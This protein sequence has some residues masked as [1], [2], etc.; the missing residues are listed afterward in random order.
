MSKKNKLWLVFGI[1]IT[2]LLSSCNCANAQVELFEVIADSPIGGELVTSLTPLFDWHGSYTCDPDEYDLFIKEDVMYGGD[3]AYSD[4]IY[5]DVPYTL[6]GYSLLPGRA[7]YWYARAHNVYTSPED[8]SAYGPDSDPAYFFTGPVCSGET[9]IAPELRFPRKHGGY[10]ET[11]NWITHNHLQEFKWTYTGGCLPVSYDYQFALDAGFTEIVLSETTTEPYVQHIFEPFSNCSSLFWRVRAND[12]TSV[13]PWSDAWQFHWVREGTSCYQTHFLSDDF[14]WLHVRLA[15]DLCDQTGYIAAWT[16]TLN[17]GCKVDGMIIVGDNSKVIDLTNFVVDLGAGPCPS[18]GLDQK[19]ANSEAKFGVLTP[20]TYCF[21]ISRNQS[22]GWNNQTYLM[23]GIWTFPRTNAVVAER[24][25]ELGP[26][27][28]DEN[29][30]FNWDEVDRTFLT[31]PLDY[32]Y[33]C[34]Y[35]PEKIC[36]TNGFAQAGETIPIL[37]R[38]SRSEWM[39]TQLN[40]TPCYVHIPG[41]LIDEYLTKFGPEGSRVAD[42]EIFPQPPPC[43]KPTPEP[44]CSSYSSQASCPARCTWHSSP[45]AAGGTCS[46]N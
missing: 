24:T 20:G 36:P 13:G 9:L 4:V 10:P 26:G 14:A 33:G 15:E 19:T 45:L 17:P 30:Q 3:S 29:I 22:I 43:P 31:F 44:A 12:G 35:G 42:L 7:Y 34:K 16:Q 11:D 32:T 5:D 18:T 37:A 2:I 21:S 25:I 38:D 23:D 40:G 1:F 41:S 28:G 6:T 8:P 27:T 46:D 39:L